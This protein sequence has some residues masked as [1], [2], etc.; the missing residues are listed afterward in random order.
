[1]RARTLLIAALMTAAAAPLVDGP[2]VWAQTATTG[3]IRGRVSDAATGEPLPGATVVATAG[4]TV[5]TAIT[6]D[7]GTYEL[8]GLAPG[9]YLL[10]FYWGG[11]S[12]ER[13]HVVVAVAKVTEVLQKL[14][15]K[16]AAG[17]A[18]TIEDRP[19]TIDRTSTTQGVTIDKE[20]T[21]NVPVPGRTFG[22]TLGA[23]AGSQGDGTGVTFSGSSSLENTY[24][25]NG[26][27]TGAVAPVAVGP[28]GE[29]EGNT[30]AYERLE[31]NPFHHVEQAPLST[32][33][34]DVDTASYAN[35]R[36]F[37]HE[38]QL[39]PPDAVRVEELLNYFRYA[40]PAPKGK[41]PFTVTTEV[42]P[43]PWHAGFEVVRV[44][45]QSAPIAD[46]DVPARNLVFLLDVS[47]SMSDANKLPLLRQAMNLLV[48]QLR[49]QDRVS[50]VVYAGAEG[51]ALPTT[52][53]GDKETIRAA[54]AG[55]EAGG[56]TNGGAGIELAYKLAQASFIRGGINR[57]VLCTDGD[58][59][60]GVTSEGD[61][62]RLIEDKREHGV[63]LTVLGFGMGNVKDSTMEALA[64]KGNGN[65]AYID[66][67]DEARKV[68]VKESGATL[69]TVA[70]DVKLQV[71]LNPAKVAGYRLIGYEDRLLADRDFADDT[72]DAGELGAG[73]A[74]TALYEI[75]PAGAKVP[76][77]PAEKL[78]YQVPAATTGS[79]ELMTIK[80]RYKPPGSD[81]STLMAFPVADATTP[82]ARTSDDFRWALAIAGFGELLRDSPERGSVAWSDVSSLAHGA[83]GPDRE[84]YRRQAVA[85]IDLARKLHR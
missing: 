7:D 36:R 62:T 29:Q 39:P 15:G 3:S 20:Y 24:V 30:E 47:G 73:H 41:Q 45:L 80:V 8:T 52:G 2:P 50:I 71:E 19:P 82:L 48:D 74:V 5:V 35:T 14:D 72:K 58:F 83:V 64:D 85:M 22:S 10:T 68:L 11:V 77:P 59:N 43:S 53:G 66:S 17:E 46:A 81:T 32:F 57:V 33:S 75:V 25:V 38:G 12:V 49:P 6:E 70:K 18:I 60:V 28:G 67:L 23:A 4:K 27:A 76:G 84:G 1:M 44:G 55:L 9:T 31:D 54:L 65:Y 37:L 21:K 34:I 56:S 26:I 78:K 61:L 13:R 16:A 63:Y 79:N 51:L 69:V 42:G 40:Y